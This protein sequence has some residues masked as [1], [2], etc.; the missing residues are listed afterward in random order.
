MVNLFGTLASFARTPAGRR[1]LRTATAKAQELAADPRAKEK[2][3]EVKDRFQRRGG[4][5]PG[6]DQPSAPD[7]SWTSGHDDEP[8]RH[9][10][11]PHRS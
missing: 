10:D 4:G 3:A 8:D 9:D 1:A 5:T 6:S 11:R 7:P 2:V